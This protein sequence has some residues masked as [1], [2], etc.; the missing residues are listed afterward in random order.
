[1]TPHVIDTG[2]LFRRSSAHPALAGGSPERRAR[3]EAPTR[4]HRLCGEIGT[5]LASPSGQRL[6]SSAGMN[7][8][9]RASAGKGRREATAL[10][11]FAD[12]PPLS[13]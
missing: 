2:G 10:P 1:M 12:S 13:S 9:T 3:R 5:A 6:T 7:P 4:K 8:P 11:A